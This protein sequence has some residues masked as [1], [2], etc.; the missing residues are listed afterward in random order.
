MH[1][2]GDPDGPCPG[3]GMV[4]YDLAAGLD[5]LR[6]RVHLEKEIRVAV[7][8]A[9]RH[10]HGRNTGRPRK[11]GRGWETIATADAEHPPEEAR[12][13]GP[14]ELGLGPLTDLGVTGAAHT[15]AEQIVAAKAPERVRQRV[16]G[17]HLLRVWPGID[18]RHPSKRPRPRT[19]LPG[20]AAPTRPDSRQ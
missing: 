12:R 5:R 13:P 17:G 10:L 16:L 9:P 2:V 14:Q 6:P 11:E 4:E 19:G 1:P 7:R 20:G 8:Q 15:V 18:T 3:D